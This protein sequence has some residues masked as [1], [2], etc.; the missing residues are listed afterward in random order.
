MSLHFINMA[1]NSYLSSDYLGA[2]H[3]NPFQYVRIWFMGSKQFQSI[4]YFNYK[5][6]ICRIVVYNNSDWKFFIFYNLDATHIE[7]WIQYVRIWFTG[8]KQ[9]QSIIYF[10]Y[11]ANICCV[12]VHNNSNWQFF[13]FYNLGATHIETWIQYVRIWFTGSKWFQSIRY[14]NY[15]ANICW[16]IVHKNSN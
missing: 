7:T 1:P 2:R 6:N 9:F 14:F 15:K 8:S 11:K 12:V 4:R 5:A 3:I 13:I 10:N 16:L